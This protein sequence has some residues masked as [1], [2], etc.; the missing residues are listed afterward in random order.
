MAAMPKRVLLIDDSGMFRQ[1]VLKILKHNFEDA[2]VKQAES[3]RQAADL[4]LNQ[5]FDLIICDL[6]L[7]DGNGY[8]ILDAIR[9]G[10]TLSRLNT[11]V[12]FLS[13]EDD[14]PL[15]PDTQ[16]FWF[17]NKSKVQKELSGL[18]RT[19]LPGSVSEN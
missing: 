18:V 16:N 11:P 12:I 1:L 9:Q 15:H 13:G 10:I 4:S 6:N 5:A 7:E 14:L 19:I 17:L 2:E 8:E 3:V